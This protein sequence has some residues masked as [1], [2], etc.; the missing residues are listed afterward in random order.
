[1]HWPAPGSALGYL[2]LT[3]PGADDLRWIILYTI[4]GPPGTP[5]TSTPREN[6]LT[7]APS[8]SPALTSA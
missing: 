5:G 3:G 1:M 4:G 2:G 8:C 6:F 7:A